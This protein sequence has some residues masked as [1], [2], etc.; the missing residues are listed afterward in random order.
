MPSRKWRASSQATSS[1]M[2]WGKVGHVRAIRG[3]RCWRARTTERQDSSVSWTTAIRPASVRTFTLESI[4]W[5]TGSRSRT[6]CHPVNR[7]PSRAETLPP[8]AHANATDLFGVRTASSLSTIAGPPGAP[9]VGALQ[10]TGSDALLQRTTPARASEASP[11][12]KTQQLLS[13]R[14]AQ[15][16]APNAALAVL[17]APRGST[18]TE[19]GVGR[20][21]GSTSALPAATGALGAARD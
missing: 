21:P 18:A 3:D 9:A 1:W 6:L 8:P 13:V 4:N 10:P 11:V 17:S 14:A 19:P 12:A 5:S 20:S 7:F 2:E 16:S 15:S